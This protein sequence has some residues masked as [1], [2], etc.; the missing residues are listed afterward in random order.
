MASS[1]AHALFPTAIGLCGIAWGQGGI[2]AVQ[3]P[4]AAPEATRRRLL[5]W[6]GACPAS[7]AP[8]DAVRAAMEGVQALLHGEPRQLLEVA[9][10]W[11]RLTPFQQRV[12]AITRGIPPGH[13][14]TY[15]EVARELG[16][17]KLARAV[18]QALGFNPFAPVVPCH[19]VLA[20]G[21]RSGGFSAQG[22]AVTKWRMLAIEGFEA[23]DTRPLLPSL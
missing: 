13:T 2:T 15:G 10:D 3:L 23:G 4:E 1:L 19:R 7:E 5:Q 12:Y 8:P 21:N 20:A 14:R 18:G 17:A 22:G 16:D 6:A 11:A 9:L